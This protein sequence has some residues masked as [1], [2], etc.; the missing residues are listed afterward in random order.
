MSIPAGYTTV[1]NYREHNN[2]STVHLVRSEK[3]K[4]TDSTLCG[5]SIKGSRWH[6]TTAQAPNCLGCLGVLTV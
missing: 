3:P 2:L 1:R 4:N 5:L 6:V